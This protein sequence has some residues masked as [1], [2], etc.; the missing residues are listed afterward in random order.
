MSNRIYPIFRIR[1]TSFYFQLEFIPL[2]ICFIGFNLIYINNL[3]KR[4]FGNYNIVM[5]IDV[6]YP[7]QCMRG[8]VEKI[9]CFGR[10]Q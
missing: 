6:S 2:D 4:R 8:L 3:Q 5:A 1:C 7:V 10:S 9:V